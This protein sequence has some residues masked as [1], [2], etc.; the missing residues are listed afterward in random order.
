MINVAF[1]KLFVFSDLGGW[2]A[3][4][5]KKKGDAFWLLEI[6]PVKGTPQKKGFVLFRS[7]LAE[8]SPCPRCFPF[9]TF[10]GCGPFSNA[11][12]SSDSRLFKEGSNENFPE[13]H[14]SVTFVRFRSER[15]YINYLLKKTCIL[16]TICRI[17]FRPTTR[18]SIYILKI[19]LMKKT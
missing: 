10:P 16:F 1:N 9:N 15:M 19:K 8:R 11:S 6:A 17:R 3:G 5:G 14:R 2:R 7:I 12:R 13:I 4:G 18:E